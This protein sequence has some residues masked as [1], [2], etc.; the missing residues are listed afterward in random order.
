MAGLKKYEIEHKTLLYGRV[1]YIT[2][3]LLHIAAI[4]I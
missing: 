2:A 3:L 4:H 1:K